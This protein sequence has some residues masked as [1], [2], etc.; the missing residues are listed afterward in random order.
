[1]PFFRQNK[2]RLRERDPAGVHTGYGKVRIIT[3]TI[4][5]FP[6]SWELEPFVAQA[7][8]HRTIGQLKLN[9]GPFSIARNLLDCHGFRFARTLAEVIIMRLQ[10]RKI[11]ITGAGGGIGRACALKFAVEGAQ[12]A[13][14]SRTRHELQRVAREIRNLGGSPLEAPCDVSREEDVH[15]LFARV[16]DEW[17][18][19]DGLL[20][21]AAIFEKVSMAE[22]SLE[23]W[24]RIIGTNLTGTFLC[25]R[26]A[27]R[28]MPAGGTIVNLAS[29]SGIPGAEKWPGLGAYNISKLGVV[30]LTEILASEGAPRGLRVNCISPGAVDTEL[31]KKAAPQIPPAL[32]PEEVAETAFFLMTDE[33]RGIN[34]ANVILAGSPAAKG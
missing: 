2:V 10:S 23:T 1:M 22:L 14:A 16:L 13:L 18:G 6:K 29:L 9:Y 5:H 33:S 26:E 27:F 21:C 31:L 15:L 32:T 17:G 25:C 34:G 7:P 12:V 19:L 8:E 3:G 20:N 30:G 11:I 4:A 28:T 24:S